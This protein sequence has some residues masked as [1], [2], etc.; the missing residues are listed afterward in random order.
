MR[1]PRIKSFI[2]A[3]STSIVLVGVTGCEVLD[4]I[5]DAESPS[6]GATGSGLIDAIDQLSI[7]EEDRTGY[8]RDEFSDWITVDGCTT[9]QLV[10]IEEDLTE[11]AGVDDCS[12]GIDGEWSSVYDDVRVSEASGLDIDHFVPLAEAWDSGADQWSAERRATYAVYLDDDRHLIAVTAASNR[13]KSDKDPAEWLP[14]DPAAHCE[15]VAT[16]VAIKI[17]WELSVDQA[18]YDALIEVAGGC[19][20]TEVEIRPVG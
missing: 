13:S 11:S 9:R 10:L 5:A 16:W 6:E 14:E 20:D 3:I 1:T 4:G 15:Y 19:S 7:E 17:Q 18:E 12:G 8:S 2:F